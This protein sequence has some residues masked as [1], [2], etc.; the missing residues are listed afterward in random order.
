MYSSFIWPLNLCEHVI[1]N[2][3]CQL[4]NKSFPYKLYLPF[5]GMRVYGW[6][7]QRERGRGNVNKNAEDRRVRFLMVLNHSLMGYNE[8]RGNDTFMKGL[9]NI[10]MVQLWNIAKGEC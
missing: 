2:A 1:W 7:C 10:D 6:D 5:D 4:S 8:C 3:V 9:P